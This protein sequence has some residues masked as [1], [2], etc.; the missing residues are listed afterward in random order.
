MKR[1]EILYLIG[2]LVTGL[3]FGAVIIG[4]SDDLRDD[5]FG[6]VAKPSVDRDNA[7]EIDA[8]SYYLVDFTE[9]QDWLAMIDPDNNETLG[10]DLTTVNDL[11][12]VV[13]ISEFFADDTQQSVENVLSVLHTTLLGKVFEN[14]Q[15]GGLKTCFGLDRASSRMYM[16]LEV[17]NE[18]SEQIPANWQKLEAPRAN[19]LLWSTQCYQA[20]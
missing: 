9:M 15:N 13:D 1:N 4:S 3:I 8:Y 7:V 14:A 2:G 16:Y 11:A 6:T 5:L 18:V 12:S 17:P 20:E 10:D 19:D